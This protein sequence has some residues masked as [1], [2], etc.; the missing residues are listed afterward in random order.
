MIRQIREAL[1]I[2]ELQ[3]L[4]LQR[5]PGCRFCFSVSVRMMPLPLCLKMPL[6]FP[7]N[8]ESREGHF[9]NEKGQTRSSS[10]GSP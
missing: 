2:L 9:L 5:M 4:Y 10:E 1:K 8:A 7:L 6:S 3:Q